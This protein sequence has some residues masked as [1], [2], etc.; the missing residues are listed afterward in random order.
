MLA[1]DVLVSFILPLLSHELS[2]VALAA[3]EPPNEL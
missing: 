3:R 2:F 1:P